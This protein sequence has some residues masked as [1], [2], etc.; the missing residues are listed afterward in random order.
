MGIF[1]KGGKFDKSIIKR[2]NVQPSRIDRIGI[3]SN[4]LNGKDTT[5]NAI[6]HRQPAKTIG[7]VLVHGFT[8]R[9][10]RGKIVT[11]KTHTRKRKT[12]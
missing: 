11:V 12:R 10:K 3:R 1:D 4:D 6:P 5:S 2:P 9:S 8:R 7:K